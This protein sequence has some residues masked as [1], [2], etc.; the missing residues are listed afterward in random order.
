MKQSNI[1][2]HSRL[3]RKRKDSLRMRRVDVGILISGKN[4]NDER[5]EMTNPENLE[6]CVCPDWSCCA[7]CG[8]FS[9]DCSIEEHRWREELRSK[10]KAHPA[11]KM[12]DYGK[13]VQVEW[14]EGGK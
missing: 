1:T 10:C 11:P 4:E 5:N 12:S 6:E 8:I 2:V 14:F 7:L 13:S 3:R 9:C